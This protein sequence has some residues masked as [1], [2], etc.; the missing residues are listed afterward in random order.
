MCRDKS[1]DAPERETLQKAVV[2]ITISAKSEISFHYYLTLTQILLS[3]ILEMLFPPSFLTEI[4]R[5]FLQYGK[6]TLFF[7]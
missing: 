3:V 7:G 2:L 4:G 6:R 5:Q 1:N